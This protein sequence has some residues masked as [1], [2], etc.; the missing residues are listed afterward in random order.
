MAAGEW[1]YS[2][3]DEKIG[4]LSSADLKQLAVNGTLLPSDLVWKQDWPE[5]KPASTIKG[6]FGAKPP[7]TSPPTPPTP[8]PARKT[9]EALRAA[10]QAADDV[11][12]KL[13]FLDLKFEQFATP[14]L[15]G[16]VFVAWLLIFS[17]I[18]VGVVL[19]ALFNLPIVQAVVVAV[20]SIIYLVVA[21][22]GLR[23]FL[24]CC[25]VVFRVAEHLS[26]LRYLKPS[27]EEIT[28]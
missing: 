24:E 6:L 4:P 26:Y 8:P 17:L 13:W 7:A 9:P 14:R 25:L 10:S 27:E 15:I 18:G 28:S 20:F 19:Y 12:Q 21:A 23:V 5:W 2:K 16:F 3:N 1:Y 11:T 22:V